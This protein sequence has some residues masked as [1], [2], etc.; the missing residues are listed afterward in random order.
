MSVVVGVAGTSTGSVGE[1]A[2]GADPD[3][4]AYRLLEL[5]EVLSCLVFT[6]ILLKNY[7]YWTRYNLVPAIVVATFMKE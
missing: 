6:D 7:Y 2:A 1:F 5:E 4:L 3:M